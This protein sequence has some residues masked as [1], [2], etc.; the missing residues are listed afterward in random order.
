MTVVFASLAV[1][2]YL[3]AQTGVSIKKLVRTLRVARS[4]TID[5]NGQRVTLEPAL[6]APAAAILASLEKGH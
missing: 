6:T 3:H 1:T 5:V 2:R 4:A